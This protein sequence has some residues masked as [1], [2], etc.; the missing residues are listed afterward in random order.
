MKNKLII[1]VL[2]LSLGVIS[3]INLSS[4]SLN[5]VSAGGTYA[6]VPAANSICHYK[7]SSYPNMKLIMVSDDDTPIDKPNEGGNQI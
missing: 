7:G 5:T 2:F 3:I 1:K 4:I 6:C